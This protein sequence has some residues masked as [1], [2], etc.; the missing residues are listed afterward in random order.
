ML[1]WRSVIANIIQ[2]QTAPERQTSLH[3]I[4]GPR[5][6]HA[7]APE[8]QDF[9]RSCWGEFFGGEFHKVCCKLKWYPH[10]HDI[11]DCYSM[12]HNGNDYGDDGDVNHHN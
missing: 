4:A 7:E 11:P 8:A 5:I 3:K 2:H 10:I 6:D 1:F 9:S 12:T